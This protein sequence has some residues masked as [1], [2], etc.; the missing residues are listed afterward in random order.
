MRYK[1]SD[2]NRYR[3]QFMR[4]TEELMDQLKSAGGTKKY[5]TEFET[6]AEAESF[7]REYGW[8]WVDENEFVWDMD[9]EEA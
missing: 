9:Y 5:F 1:N 4:S 7:C 2:D 8:E 3:V 6:E